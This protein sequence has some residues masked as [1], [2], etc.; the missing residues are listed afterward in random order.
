[1]VDTQGLVLKV[2]VLPANVTDAEGGKACLQLAWA[3][4]K[5]FCHLLVDGGCKRQFEE[6]VQQTLGWSVQV[7]QRPDANFRGI[8]WPDDKPM[9]DDLVQELL[10][11]TP[12]FRSLVVM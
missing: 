4:L 9:P 10:K 6:W 5:R 7:M 8:W 3:S 12:G 2:K 11:K 1:M